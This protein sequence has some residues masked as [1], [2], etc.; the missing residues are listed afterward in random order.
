MK[1][2]EFPTLGQITNGSGAMETP[3]LCCHLSEKMEST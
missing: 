2:E 1:E 3:V